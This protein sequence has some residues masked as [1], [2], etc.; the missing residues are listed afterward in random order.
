V[1]R[2]AASAVLDAGR[3]R[4]GDDRVD[5]MSR[6]GASMSAEEIVEFAFGA[7]T[8]GVPAGR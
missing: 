3:R 4:H 2:A 5:A 7:A 6:S 1:E 8:A